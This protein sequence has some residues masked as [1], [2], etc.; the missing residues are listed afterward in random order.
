M[1]SQGGGELG[2]CSL[3]RWFSAQLFSTGLTELGGA[4]PREGSLP[5]HLYP[6]PHPHPHPQLGADSGMWLVESSCRAEHR[7]LQDL[8]HLH[9]PD[10][11]D[12]SPAAQL[13]AKGAGRTLPWGLPA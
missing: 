10:P 2:Q 1:V 7:K 3:L 8:N 13:P 11:S 12:L 4:W 5:P 9:Q 6:P